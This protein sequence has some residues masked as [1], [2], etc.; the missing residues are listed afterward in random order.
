MKGLTIILLAL[1][2]WCNA[3]DTMVEKIEPFNVAGIAITTTNENGKSATDMGALWGKF[4][5]Q[6]ISNLVPNKM[7]DAV[8]AIYSEYESD[9]TGEY[10]AIIGHRVPSLENL[11]EGMVGIQVSGGNYQKHIARGGM[12]QAVLDVWQTI[13]DNDS[14]LNRAYDTDFEVYGDKANQGANSEVE[15]YL[16]IK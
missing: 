6:N 8:Y 4:Y 3:Q 7:S 11:P 10:L 9:Y 5:S 15:I 13:W 12:P 2:Y 14:Q 16:S 1:A